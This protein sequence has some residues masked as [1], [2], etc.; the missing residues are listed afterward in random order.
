MKQIILIIVSLF[1]LNTATSQIWS[2]RVVDANS[3]KSIEF[4]NIGV[5]HKNKGTVTNDNGEFSFALNNL[6]ANDTIRVSCIGYQ[7]Y[8]ILVSQCQNF[9]IYT[10]DFLIALT[11]KSFSINEVVVTSSKVKK[12]V[13]GNNV[14]MALIVGGFQ[15]RSLGAEMGTVLKYRKKKKGQ[16]ISLNFNFI[17]NQADSIFFRVNIYK[18]RNGMPS[19]N[20]LKKPIYLHGISKNGTITINVSKENIYIRKDCFLALELVTA[21]GQDGL[22]F[23]SAFLQS[24]SYFR[25]TSQSNWKKAPLDLGFWAEIIYKK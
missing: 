23:K 13:R 10:S 11:P 9:L 24:P 22:F 2:G 21:I 18:M 19:K 8:D 12:I 4:V 16:L 17:G 25:E 1:T 15:N 20:I 3:K 14:K 7:H 5:L 6:L